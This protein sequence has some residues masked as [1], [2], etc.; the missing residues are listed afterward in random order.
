MHANMEGVLCQIDK[1]LLVRVPIVMDGPIAIKYNAV[2]ATS[3][4]TLFVSRVTFIGK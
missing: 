2:L 1:S 3:T 4:N